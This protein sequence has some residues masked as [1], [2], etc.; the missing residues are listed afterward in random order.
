[1]TESPVG[2]WTRPDDYIEALALKRAF[3]RKRRGRERTEP[4][5][6]RLLLSTV[7]F[8]ALLGLLGVLAVAIM[9]AAF[10]GTQPEAKTPPPPAR[11]QGVA[12]RGWFEEA[13]REFHH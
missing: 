13:Q 3:R 1:M 12:A 5:S 10:P 2:K 11:Q 4:E 8:L 6:P 9:V 7:P